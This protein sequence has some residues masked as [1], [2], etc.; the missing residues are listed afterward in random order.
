M[1]IA[2]FVLFAFSGLWLGFAYYGKN[3]GW[4]PVSRWGGGFI[5]SVLIFIFVPLNFDK[6]FPT[7]GGK[8]FNYSKPDEVISAKSIASLDDAK[9]FLIG[10]WTFT[11]PIKNN[12]PSKPDIWYW[13]KWIVKEDGT[14]DVY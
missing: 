14:V 2:F 10:T 1:G 8:L 12:N 5:F 13:E 7:S 3:E 4:S 9:R 11:D 6:L